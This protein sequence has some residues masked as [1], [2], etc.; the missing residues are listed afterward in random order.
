MQWSERIDFFK[1]TSLSSAQVLASKITF[2]SY[3]FFHFTKSHAVENSD[4]SAQFGPSKIF[5]SFIFLS[6]LFPKADEVFIAM[7]VTKIA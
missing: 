7:V 4:I 2:L 1:C 6:F 5:G 3:V